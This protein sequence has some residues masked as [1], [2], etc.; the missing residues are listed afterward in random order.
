M[1]CSEEQLPRLTPVAVADI[2]N[3]MEKLGLRSTIIPGFRFS[4]AERTSVAGPAL[5]VRKVPKHSPALPSERLT[6]HGEVSKSMA[7]HG[8]FVVVDAGARMYARI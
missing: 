4:I 5:T 2:S 1:T 6:R 7:Q 3:A 8:D